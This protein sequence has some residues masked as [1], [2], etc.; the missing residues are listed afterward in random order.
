M[1]RFYRIADILGSAYELDSGYRDGNN[2]DA[3]MSPMIDHEG[4]GFADG[5]VRDEDAPPCACDSEAQEDV[6]ETPIT[7]KPRQRFSALSQA[8]GGTSV[9]FG[10]V[11]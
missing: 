8:Q 3:A 10:L 5:V 6:V 7:I 1:C 2:W 9:R 11:R 4:I